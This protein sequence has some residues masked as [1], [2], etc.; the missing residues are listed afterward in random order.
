MTKLISISDYC[1]FQN[2]WRKSLRTKMKQFRITETAPTMMYLKEKYGRP[3]VGGR[4]RSLGGP[5]ESEAYLSKRAKR[6]PLVSLKG[7]VM[8]VVDPFSHKK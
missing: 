3:G 1:I 5:E 6:C 2:S 4:K 7:I 8:T